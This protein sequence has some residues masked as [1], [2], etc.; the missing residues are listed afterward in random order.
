[1]RI[2]DWSSDVC[3]ADLRAQ[4]L[5]VRHAGDFDRILEA[6]EQPRGG[7]L[8]RFEGE[9]VDSL[10]TLVTPALSRGPASFHRRQAGPRLKAGVTG[11]G[12]AH[13][14]LGHLITG[15]P[16]EPVGQSRLSRAIV[17]HD[18]LAFARIAA[19]SQTLHDR[20]VVHGCMVVFNFTPK[21]LHPLLCAQRLLGQ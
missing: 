13:R 5:D 4:E 20:L 8:V 3:S 6:E 11:G 10:S 7:A 14:S 12:E 16:A 2:S 19:L 15:P 17:P 21:L 1:M 9:Q 18:P